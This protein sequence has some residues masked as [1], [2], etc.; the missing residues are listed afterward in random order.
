MKDV[1]GDFLEDVLKEIENLRLRNYSDSTAEA[2]KEILKELVNEVDME[3]D[4]DPE[5]DKIKI[6]SDSIYSSVDGWIDTYY[7]DLL[8]WLTKDS[9]VYVFDEY[10]K[11]NGFDRDLMSTIQFA[12][13]RDI[14]NGVY[15]AIAEL[16]DYIDY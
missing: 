8:K 14:E 5:I 15:S 6:D 4:F 10:V 9:N 1:A 13:G 2:V 7:N 3:P 11:E 12:Q 16:S